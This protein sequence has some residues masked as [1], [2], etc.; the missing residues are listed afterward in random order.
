MNVSMKKGWNKLT[1][2]TCS[3]DDGTAKLSTRRNAV[4]DADDIYGMNEKRAGGDAKRTNIKAKFLKGF[5]V[6]TDVTGIVMTTIQHVQAEKLDTILKQQIAATKW[7]TMNFYRY[8]MGAKNDNFPTIP[9]TNAIS[10]TSQTIAL[11]KNMWAEYS[12]GEFNWTCPTGHGTLNT[13][14][15]CMESEVVSGISTIKCS[16]EAFA[17]LTTA[18]YAITGPGASDVILHCGLNKAKASAPD[19]TFYGWDSSDWTETPSVAVSEKGKTYYWYKA[20]INWYSLGG[21]TSSYT[22]TFTASLAKSSGDKTRPFKIWIYHANYSASDIKYFPPKS[23]ST[24]LVTGST[25]YAYLEMLTRQ[26]QN[27]ANFTDFYWE[28]VG[29]FNSTSGKWTGNGMTENG[30]NVSMVQFKAYV[31]TDTPLSIYI[32]VTRPCTVTY[33]SYSSGASMSGVKETKF[34][35]YESGK[36][37]KG[38]K[39]SLY[40][41]HYWYKYVPNY[42]T[43]MGKIIQI[44]AYT[45]PDFELIAYRSK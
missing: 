40:K 3:L 17:C 5:S 4:L 26:K 43:D 15:G 20:L 39:P 1:R 2:Q 35:V 37:Y 29:N 31:E 18:Y 33:A 22:G 38:T 36:E 9:E 28:Y 30:T 19:V 11:T 12:I 8:T 27:A 42:T 7:H 34:E 45:V 24:E 10:G 25:E 13:E 14:L 44:K 16:G 41:S 32:G 6:L 21:V 23:L